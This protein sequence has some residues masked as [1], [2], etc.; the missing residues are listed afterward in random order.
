MSPRAFDSSILENPPW[1]KSKRKYKMG[2][3]PTSLDAWITTNPKAAIFDHK[4]QLLAENYDKVVASTEDSQPGQIA[5]AEFTEL[6]GKSVYPDSIANI[7][8][9]I[10]EDVCIIDTSDKNRFIAGCVCSPSYWDLNKKI[11]QPLWDV[12]QAVDG[13]NNY[14]GENIDR[15]I[16]GLTHKRPFERENWFVH[17]NTKRM[18]LSPEED[19]NNEPNS[20]FIRTERETL[21]RI[22]EDF[23]VFTINPRFVPLHAILDYPQALDSLKT[24]LDGFTDEEIIYFGGRKKFDQLACFLEV[25]ATSS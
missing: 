4:K 1:L 21:C 14:L 13:L 23:I 11:G 7:A 3:S 17:G 15:F 12:H 5:L 18:H 8:S 2:L 20:W 24:V 10:A 19:L 6:G 16:N 25:N 22:H 9:Q